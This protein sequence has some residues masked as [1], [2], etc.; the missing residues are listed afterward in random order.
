[1]VVDLCLC[2]LVFVRLVFRFLVDYTLSDCGGALLLIALV[3][4][5]WFCRLSPWFLGWVYGIVI[6]LVWVLICIL[7]I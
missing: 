2:L 6:V 7:G 4:G 1:M 5:V 3:A